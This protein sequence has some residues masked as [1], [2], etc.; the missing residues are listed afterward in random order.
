M[1][2]KCPHCGAGLP[3]GSAFCPHCARDVH[4]RRTAGKPVPLRKSL[5]LGLAVL[6][7]IAAAAAALWSRCG[8]YV[9]Q[10]YDGMGEVHYT[11]GDR[12]Y[13]LL[14]AWPNDRCQSAPDIYQ[15]G[16]PD[17]DYRWPSRWYV[18]DAA[19]GTDAWTEFEPLVEQVTVEVIQDENAA[20]VPSH[21]D[22]SPDAAMVSYLDFTGSSGKPQV[23]WTARMKNGDVIRVRQNIHITPIITHVYN[24]HDYPMGTIEELQTLLDQIA[25]ETAAS[26]QVE[27]YL[28]AV[29]Y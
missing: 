19:T 24:W 20:T 6:I 25:G 9:P 14:V 29:T 27:V 3:E 13:Q 7:V 1:E 21:D 16:G 10:E 11:S 17:D 28:P 2:R 4:P 12:T 18:N 23:V 22:Y 8:A 15:Q 26:D 5:I